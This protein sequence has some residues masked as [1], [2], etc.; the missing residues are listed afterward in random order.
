MGGAPTPKLLVPLVLTHSHISKAMTCLA[1]GASHFAGEAGGGA[2][3]R[4]GAE[5]L[6]ARGRVCRTPR[7]PAASY[8]EQRWAFSAANV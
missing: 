2:H 5:P 6:L 4:T 8:F 7:L 1:Q 3:C